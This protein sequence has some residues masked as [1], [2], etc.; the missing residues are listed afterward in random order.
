[1]DLNVFD[2][3]PLEYHYF[4]MFFHE[5]EE[6]RVDDPRGNLTCLSKYTKGD[7]NRWFNPKGFRNA[8]ALLEGKYGNLYNIMI[9]YNK[10]IKAWLHSQN[11]WC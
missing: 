5:I 11:W 9:M 2:C 4:M 10:E 7:A 1:M 8:K 6:K 3:N